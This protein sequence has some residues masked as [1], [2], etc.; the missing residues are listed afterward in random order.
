MADDLVSKYISGRATDDEI[1]RLRAEIEADPSRVDD[2]FEASELERDLGEVFRGGKV[3]IAR[4]KPWALIA[5]AAVVA[6]AV[7]GYITL[8]RDS[9]LRVAVVDSVEGRVLRGGAPLAAGDV[10][11]TGDRI[12]AAGR[13]VLRYPDGTQLDLAPGTVA[14]D[15]AAEGGKR[16]TVERGS[17][18]GDVPRQHADQPLTL[19]TPEGEARVLGTRFTLSTATGVSRL[20]VDKGVVRLTRL[21]DGKSA[22]VAA[23]Q[24]AVASAGAAPVARPSVSRMAPGTWLAVPETKMAAVAPD[25]A[26]FPSTRGTSGPGAVIGAW[27]GGAFDSRRGR[28]VLWGGGYSDYAGNELYA[29]DV[30]ALSWR[31]LTDPTPKP[32]LN[33]EANADGTPNSRATYNGLAY[34]AH[35]DRFFALGGARAGNGFGCATPW[36]FD[37]GAANWSTL[38]TSGSTPAS[39]LGAVCSAD[40]ATRKLW[41]GDSS[42][43]YSLDGDRWTKHSSD[44]WYYFTGAIDPKRGLWILVGNGKV[45]AVDVR[46][47]V[48]SRQAWTTTGGDAFIAKTNVG[49]DYD[50]KR[51]RIVGWAG[52]PVYT[53]DP[54][55]KIWTAT[56]A[57]GAPSPTPN[58][59]FGRWRYVP[60]VDAFVVVTAIDQDVHFFKPAK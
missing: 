60:A 2:L 22:E 24:M 41:W 48:A 53:L 43:T 9:P 10:V 37:F 27:S 42:G 17:V 20:N 39:G 54:E 5:A 26:A 35:A 25:A 21:A 49:L 4:R 3:V 12:D 45:Y 8:R 38:P 19:K 7:G 56:D 14:K 18:T 11:V 23:G 33:E 55:T 57:P 1:A 51:D 32:R 34:M 50:P 15:L 31:R 30:G 47:G 44:D 29:F 36:T 16:M 40:P 59:I 58:G 52:G 28:L 46:G 13:V 6:I